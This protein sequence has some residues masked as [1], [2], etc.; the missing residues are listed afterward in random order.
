MLV[1]SLVNQSEMNN[2]PGLIYKER[3][4][5]ICNDIPFPNDKVS[6]DNNKLDL[7]LFETNYCYW[8]KCS[9]CGIN[10]K[11]C[12]QNERQKWNIPEA[13]NILKERNKNG[14]RYIWLTDEAIPPI[15]LKKL[16][17]KFTENQFNFIWHFRTRIEPELLDPELIEL[18]KNNGVKSIILGFES[19][20][21]R[22]LRLMK[23]TFCSDYLSIAEKI[24]E[25]YTSNGIHIH[26]PVLIGFPTETNDERNYSL[27]FVEYLSKS[28]NCFLTI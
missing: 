9:F 19:A 20:S 7:K 14:N 6:I 16:L 13:I 15:I 25:K 4:E 3:G 22:I 5:I 27:Q 17:I 24:V 18:V 12:T 28:M 2:I 21:E 11:Y 26:F 8:N 23:K 1:N 10:H